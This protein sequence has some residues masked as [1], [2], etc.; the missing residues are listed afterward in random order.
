MSKAQENKY[1]AGVTCP[2]H[3]GDNLGKPICRVCYDLLDTLTLLPDSLFQERVLVGMCPTCY[4]NF[5]VYNNPV[6]WLTEDD[7]R[8][9]KIID[10]LGD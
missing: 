5:H 8:C 10:S 7:C 2:V 1:I 4:A 3:V 6:H 9:S